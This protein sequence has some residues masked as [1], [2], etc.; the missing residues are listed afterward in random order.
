MWKR[1]IFII[2]GSRFDDLEGFYCEV[3]RVFTK[4]IPFETGH[5]LDAF[6][7]ILRGGFGTHERGEPI[8]IRWISFSKSRKDLGYAATAEYH[9]D[10][11]KHCHPS[12]MECVT[13]RLLAAQQE[14]GPTLIDTIIKIITNSDNS[15]HDCLLEIFD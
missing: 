5:N 6:N 15:G 8:T 7:D 1:P 11:L 9:K 2:D 14:V 10:I 4:D 3:D 13:K 12:A